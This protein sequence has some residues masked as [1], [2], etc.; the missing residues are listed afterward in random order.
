MKNGSFIGYFRAFPYVCD[1]IAYNVQLL[2]KD[3]AV[4]NA[5]RFIY[6]N[7]SVRHNKYTGESIYEFSLD[8]RYINEQNFLGIHTFG[9]SIIENNIVTDNST[10][11]PSSAGTE[12]TSLIYSATE[13]HTTS[14]NNDLVE[15]YRTYHYAFIEN[16]TQIVQP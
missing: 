11:Y 16:F 1:A 3:L 14:N 2:G 9:K 8:R 6:A 10:N 7:Q 15:I 4:L 13:P 12:D 5:S